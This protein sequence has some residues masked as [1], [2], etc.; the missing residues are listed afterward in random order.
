M[1]T[2]GGDRVRG[3][4]SRDGG[5]LEA[6]DG[7]H[8]AS[9]WDSGKVIRSKLLPVLALTTGVLLSGCAPISSSS[10]SDSSSD[11]VSASDPIEQ[12]HVVVGG[13]YSYAEIQTA[14]DDA[15]RAAGEGLTDES[16]SRAWSSILATKEGLVDKGYPAPDS[17]TVMLCV[18]GSVTTRSVGL[19][20]AIAYC[21]LEA[22][23]I[24]ESEW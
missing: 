15:L 23:G 24:P 14:T 6:S 9:E 19:T 18:P 8:T 1:C 17:M 11:N 7:L 21:S 16:R 12:A 13:E 10:D 22:A 20:E 2:C 5:A 3:L 4:L